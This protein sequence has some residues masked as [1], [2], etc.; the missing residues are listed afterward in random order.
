MRQEISTVGQ[1]ESA[2]LELKNLASPCTRK[3]HR[4]RAEDTEWREVQ[5]KNSAH[6]A[7]MRKNPKIIKIANSA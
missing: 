2:T 1:H 7:V 3:L 4:R 6:S 5:M